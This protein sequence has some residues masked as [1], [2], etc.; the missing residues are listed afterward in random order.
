MIPLRL[1]LKNASLP[2]MGHTNDRDIVL[3]A[4]TR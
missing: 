2:Q 4:G 1:T 3:N